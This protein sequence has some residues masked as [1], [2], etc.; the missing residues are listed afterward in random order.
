[1]ENKDKKKDL[2]KYWFAL[3]AGSILVVA[4]FFIVIM[5]KLELNSLFIFI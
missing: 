5:L 1:M 4:F 2:S 3:I